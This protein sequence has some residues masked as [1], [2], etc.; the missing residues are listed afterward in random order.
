MNRIQALLNSIFCIECKSTQLQ[1]TIDQKEDI[2]QL[3]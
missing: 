3:K 2:K 1:I